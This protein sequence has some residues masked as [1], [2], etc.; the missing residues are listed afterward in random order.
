M[1]VGY[2]GGGSKGGADDDGAPDDAGEQGGKGGHGLRDI[3][4]GTVVAA[5]AEQTVMGGYC[6]H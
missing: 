2:R 4:V 1:V 6:S 5:Y 3:D